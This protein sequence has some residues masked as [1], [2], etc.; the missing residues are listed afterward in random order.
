MRIW[1]CMLAAILIGATAIPIAVAGS[2]DGA[3]LRKKLYS[4]RKQTLSELKRYRAPDVVQRRSLYLAAT[5][6][7]DTFSKGEKNFPSEMLD[8]AG[9]ELDLYAE[10]PG[11]LAMVAEKPDNYKGGGI[12][13]FRKPDLSRCAVL[14]A[15]HGFFDVGTS[16]IGVDAFFGSSAQTLM[17]NSAHRYTGNRAAKQ[18][19][20]G[21]DLAHN[22]NN[23][24][25]SVFTALADSCQTGTFIQI[26]G[27]DHPADELAAHKTQNFIVSAGDDEGVLVKTAEKAA[28]ILRKE[29]PG[30]KIAVFGQGRKGRL[31][32]E[33]N[34]HNKYLQGKPNLHFLH[35]ETDPAT[36]ERL[37]KDKKLK[38]QFHK[39]LDR[40]LGGD[41]SS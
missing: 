12:Y 14:M 4:I 20:Y 28:E 38:A 37:V 22:R 19:K 27:F 6:L 30:L 18:D 11:P 36:R 41:L 34:V 7:I 16:R 23:F 29:M 13:L 1:L 24:Y 25:Y 35:L 5:E 10:K 9:F 8:K 2:K 21:S 40:I 3:S 39:A 17:I 31:G 26:H 15:P 33:T 32:G